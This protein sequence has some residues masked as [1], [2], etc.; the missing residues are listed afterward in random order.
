MHIL[1]LESSAGSIFM[2]PIMIYI[3]GTDHSNQYI[4]INGHFEKSEMYV[5]VLEML[6]VNKIEVIA[7]ELSEDAIS[8]HNKK[9][10]LLRSL[11]CKYNI[12]H[13]FVDM[14]EA[15]RVALG[16]NRMKEEYIKDRID[17][18]SELKRGNFSISSRREYQE[19]QEF[20]FPIRENFWYE[21]LNDVLDKNILFV[22]GSDH[23]KSFSKLLKLKGHEVTII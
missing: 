13:L 2:I 22:C 4:D 7:E 11:A 16:Y 12:P 20:I 18:N 10:S 8:L 14:T 9:D 5:K 17:K 15:Q 1:R 3:L 23:I 21:M 6:E 19:L